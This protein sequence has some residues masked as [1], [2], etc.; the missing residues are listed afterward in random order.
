MTLKT[1]SECG[2]EISSSAEA[3]P[4]CGLKPRRTKPVTWLVLGLIILIFFVSMKNSIEKENQ[5]ATERDRVALLTPE[6]RSAEQKKK[7]EAAAREAKEKELDSARFVCEEF[8][9]RSLH[10]PK[11]AE[12]GSRH[13]YRT[14][15]QADVYHVQ[16]Q[17]RAKN[18]FNATRAA[19]FDCKTRRVGSDW[20][21]VSVAQQP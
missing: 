8:V 17:V 3:C 1:C 19:V 9:R 5:D 13:G 21:M 4:H 7:A 2:K 15:Q 11:S 16:V 14:R 18:A 10:D 12:F 20:A 6:Q